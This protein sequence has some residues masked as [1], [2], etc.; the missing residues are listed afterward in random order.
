MSRLYIPSEKIST[1]FQIAGK[2]QCKGTDNGFKQVKIAY[3]AVIN[4]LDKLV[5]PSY[6][7]TR[8]CVTLCRTT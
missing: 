8:E 2:L 5:W 3:L 1:P 4:Y 7:L 6:T